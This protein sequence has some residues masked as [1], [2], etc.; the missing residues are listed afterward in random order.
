MGLLN[1]V[2]GSPV[3]NGN[4]DLST[5]VVPSP[6]VGFLL[7][8]VFGLPMAG[9]Q[10]AFGRRS[11]GL[12]RPPPPEEHTDAPVAV[13]DRPCPL[14]GYRF[15]VGDG[16]V[17]QAKRERPS[18]H[19]AIEDPDAPIVVGKCVAL[20]LRNFVWDRHVGNI[21]IPSTYANGAGILFVGMRFACAGF[22][23]PC[24]LTGA[25]ARALAV[26]S[27]VSARGPACPSACL[28]R[29][30]SRAER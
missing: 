20:I 24:A 11:G 10:V 14:L 9:W 27:C 2:G 3:A 18:A 22:V 5:P 25:L 4:S 26:A 28:G 19:F 6:A 15:V 13:L 1:L 21:K 7:G 16:E 23:I 30:V 29:G 17:A 8:G 12:G